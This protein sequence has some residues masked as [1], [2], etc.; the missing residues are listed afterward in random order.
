MERGKGEGERKISDLTLAAAN[1]ISQLL[2]QTNKVREEVKHVHGNEGNLEDYF[3]ISRLSTA[4]ENIVSTLRRISNFSSVPSRVKT[5]QNILMRDPLSLKDVYLEAVELQ[6]WREALIDEVRSNTDTYAQSPEVYNQIISTLGGHFEAVFTLSSSLRKH[7]KEN[8]AN[9]FELAMECPELLVAAVEVLLLIEQRNVDNW[10]M[11]SE[12]E[13]ENLPNVNGE[14]ENEVWSELKNRFDV[15]IQRQYSDYV[16]QAADEGKTG[17]EATLGA[18]TRGLVDMNLLCE[19]VECCFPKSMR[20][21][22]V[23]RERFEEYMKPQVAALYSQNFRNIELGDLLRLISW[24]HQYN[25]QIEA[26]QV[27]EPLKEFSAAVDELMD[28][29]LTRMEEQ[30]C[31]W[32]DNIR[33]RESNIVEDS[34]GFLVTREPEDILNIINMQI[35][36]AKDS[37]PLV[38]C[39]RTVLGCVNQLMD[40]QVAKKGKIE[41]E[42]EEMEIERIC[43]VVNDSNR[44]QEKCENILVENNISGGSEVGTDM[45]ARLEE[46]IEELCS[47]YVSLAVVAL[48]HASMSVMEDLQEPILSKIFAQNWENGDD[49]V[50]V[51]VQTLRD[52]FGDLKKWLPEYFFGKLVKRCFEKVLHGYLEATMNRTKAFADF[53]RSAQIVAH[54]ALA[55]KSLFCGDFES[56]LRPI[57]GEEELEILNDIAKLIKMNEPSED[58]AT[59]KRI[60]L[61]FGE[62]SGA[63]AVFHYAG[64]KKGIDKAEWKFAITHFAKEVEVEKGT[65]GTREHGH[66]KGIQVPKAKWA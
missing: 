50:S 13:Q 44:F 43:T 31:E 19:E 11:L 16:F 26:F 34:E 24:L 48:D 12:E 63:D 42:W 10:K 54:D 7:V 55:L 53:K 64:L 57:N 66:L 4:H 58:E 59:I 41:E 25:S 14:F 23:Y 29:Y 20:V 6:D 21:A 9:C 52:Y 56:Y 33:K 65:G 40:A 17:M 15:R 1:E 46:A 38:L 5:L 28:D 45:V 35:S 49:L 36:V 22:T 47:G 61:S 60:L 51:T 3:H 8:I 37:L 62:S 32:F 2:Q 39:Y 18:A 27:G 30:V